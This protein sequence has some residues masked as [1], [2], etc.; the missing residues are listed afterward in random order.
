MQENIK[1][2]HPGL[3]HVSSSPLASGAPTRRASCA[4]T[5]GVVTR[6]MISTRNAGGENAEV[7]KGVTSF[8]ESLKLEDPRLMDV[9]QEDW[10]QGPTAVMQTIFPSVIIQQQVNSL[11]TRQII[12]Q[13]PDAFDFVWTHFGFADDAPEMTER[14]L[15]QANLFGFTGPV[16]PTTVR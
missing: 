1:T 7:T 8:K 15:K 16:S 14:R 4:L 5:R 13:G 9:V 6:Q 12:P 10:W 3:L 2:R 11:S